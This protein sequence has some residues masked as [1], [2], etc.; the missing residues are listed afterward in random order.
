[1]NNE[2]FN[3]D[4]Y[5]DGLRD[6]SVTKDDLAELERALLDDA[7]LRRE[8]RKRMRMEG[9][10]HHEMQEAPADIIP[11]S[12]QV[13][14]DQK[15]VRWPIVV[16]LGMVAAV[17]MAVFI[18]VWSM[19]GRPEVIARIESSQGAAWAE[20]LMENGSGLAAGELHLLSGLATLRFESGAVVDLEA[21]VTIELIDSMRCRLAQGK[22]VFE[23]PESA[24]GFVVEAPGGYAVDHGT[25]FAVT[26]NQESE[27]AEFGVMNGSIS[28]FHD[29]AK[30]SA[31]LYGGELVSLSE[32]GISKSPA[33]N[34][35][36]LRADNMVVF[37][38]NGREDSVVRG[39]ERQLYLNSNMLM[40]KKDMPSDRSDDSQLSE[41]IPKDRRAL[42]G[43][44]M[45]QFDRHRVERAQ[46][47]LNLIPSGLG[48]AKFMPDVTVFKVYGVRDD[49]RYESWLME[50]LRWD[51][52]PGAIGS[53]L[54][55][56]D[57]SVV[58]LGTFEVP[59][60]MTDGQLIFESAELDRF[61]REDTTGIVDFLLLTETAPIESWS[62]VHAFAASSHTAASGP[63]LLVKVAAEKLEK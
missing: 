10:L 23:V 44:D 18:A 63:T 45:R 49:A 28:V 26:V 3:F 37:K 59:R 4:R 48:Y 14:A 61:V 57:S 53:T 52:A 42:F 29:A 12:M 62:R 40:V 20:S 17:F 8:Y 19:P 6:G 31:T 21:P 1:M 54:E 22:A 51:S 43:F 16:A 60:S 5:I 24:H 13:D 33:S 34:I 2:E 30:T 7:E 36:R 15:I 56:D 11:A 46:L 50:D 9:S 47:K 25:Q 32:Q 58:F 27:H 55:V 39:D 35:E 38:T 41:S